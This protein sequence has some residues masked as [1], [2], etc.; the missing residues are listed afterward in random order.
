MAIMRSL[1]EGISKSAI[2]KLGLS[3]SEQRADSTH[4]VSNICTRGR[5]DLFAKTMSHFIKSLDEKRFSRI[6]DNIKR[7]HQRDREGWF[8]LGLV[9][10]SAKLE[11]LA[12]YVNKLI[13]IFKNDQQ[14]TAAE[15]YQL[16]VRLFKEQCEVVDQSDSDKGSGTG[17]KIKIKTK[18]KG[19]TLQSPF[20]P[21]ASYGHKG[22]GYS[23]HI[24]ETCNNQHKSEIITD[25]E[26]NTAARSDKGKASDIVNRLSSADLKPDTL[27]ADG[28]YPSAPSALEVVEKDVEFI[29]PVDRAR[30]P[31]KVMGRNRFE[32]DQDGFLVQ[33]PQGHKPVDH[34]MRSSNNQKGSA[35]HAIFNG[36]TCRARAA[37]FD[38][39]RYAVPTTANAAVILATAKVNLGLKSPPSFDCVIKCMPINKPMRGKSATKFVQALR[40]PCRS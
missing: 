19:Q 29:A 12:R 6:A 26:V 33:C 8:G 11:Q 30:L 20:D 36:D 5:L 27:Y 15:P 34:R 9:Q 39:A 17:K 7:W 2:K 28:G 35:L 3:T 31:E 22:Q 14:V 16:L 25:Y 1:F 24:T 38:N 21:D 10:R 4:I 18:S 37:N 13:V 23:A 32:F 40:P